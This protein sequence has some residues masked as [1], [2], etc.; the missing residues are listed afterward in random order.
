MPRAYQP[1][2]AYVQLTRDEAAALI[3]LLEGEGRYNTAKKI[4]AAVERMRPWPPG[5][6][7]FE[8]CSDFP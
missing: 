2:A 6:D 3:E 5:D 4:R 1:P 7:L 8:P